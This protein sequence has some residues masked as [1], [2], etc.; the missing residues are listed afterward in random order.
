MK[1]LAM[2]TDPKSIARFLTTLG[3]PAD[4]PHRLPAR[5]PP[6]WRSRVLRRMTGDTARSPPHHAPPVATTTAPRPRAEREKA[7][8]PPTLLRPAAQARFARGDNPR[9]ATPDGIG[10]RDDAAEGPSA[11]T[12]LAEQ[13]IAAGATIVGGCCGTGPAHIAELARL[14]PLN[15]ARSVPFR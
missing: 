1:L 11:Y 2:V 5:G 4:P 10:W 13:W 15:S 14:R 6:Y 7:L 12:Q 9:L 8:M 3:E